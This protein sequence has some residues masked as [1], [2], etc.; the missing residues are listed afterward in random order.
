MYTFMHVI[1]LFFSFVN[2]DEYPTSTRE[3]DN[4]SNVFIFPVSFV[5]YFILF[6]LECLLQRNY[7]FK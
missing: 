2:M 1:I 6:S 3:R 4:F 5:D 7:K